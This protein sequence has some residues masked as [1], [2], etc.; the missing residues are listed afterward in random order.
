VPSYDFVEDVNFFFNMFKSLG[1][2][3]GRRGNFFRC[4]SDRIEYPLQPSNALSSKAEA[5]ILKI[6]DCLAQFNVLFNFC[7][8]S[9]IQCFGLTV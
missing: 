6:C 4:G 9:C 1:N 2:I 5:S 7:F 3:F 8:N